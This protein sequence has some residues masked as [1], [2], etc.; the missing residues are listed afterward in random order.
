M[1]AGLNPDAT[2]PVS[3]DL[4]E[5]ADILVV[6][7]ESHRNKLSKKFGSALKGKRIVVLG[8]PDEYEYMQ[9]ELV[10]LL[11]SVVPRHCGI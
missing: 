5:W 9:P 6:M 4:V 7:E 8:I 1:S 11:K 10:R 3:S 2:T